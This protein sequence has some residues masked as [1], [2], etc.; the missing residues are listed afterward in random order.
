MQETNGKAYITGF[1]VLEYGSAGAPV[2]YNYQLYVVV[3]TINNTMQLCA[4]LPDSSAPEIYISQLDDMIKNGDAIV[5]TSLT[6][7]SKEDQLV[8]NRMQQ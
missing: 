7:F 1:T 2:E 4:I 3:N 8:F 5:L 6:D